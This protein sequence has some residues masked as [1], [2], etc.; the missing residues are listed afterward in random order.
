MA[1]ITPDS[2]AGF[3]SDP[4]HPSVQAL[5][6]KHGQAHFTEKET[7]ARNYNER[8]HSFKMLQ[9]GFQHTHSDPR[10]CVSSSSLP[11]L[12]CSEESVFLQ[13]CPKSGELAPLLALLSKGLLQM[14]W[15]GRHPVETGDQGWG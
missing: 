10:V 2:G 15:R 8:T 14:V 1:L 13:E 6:G 5:A 11:T 7:E 3:S 9:S 4:F 12:S